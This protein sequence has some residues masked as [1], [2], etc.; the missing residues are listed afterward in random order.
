[1]VMAAAI[2]VFCTSAGFAVGA[3]GAPHA[4]TIMAMAATMA[5]VKS[6]FM[7]YEYLLWI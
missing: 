6:G 3:A 5:K 7:R 2:A 4:L 1:M